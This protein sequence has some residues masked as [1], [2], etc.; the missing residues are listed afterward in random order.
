MRAAASAASGGVAPDGLLLLLEQSL[1]FWGGF[2]TIEGRIIDVHHPQ[3]GQTVGGQ[4]VALP[5]TKG[6]AGTP[7]D[8]AEAIRLGVGP[9]AV[10]T[11]TI[12][13]NIVA[14]AMV[15][16][17]LYGVDVPILRLNVDDF[18]RL[19]TGQRL[20]IAENGTIYCKQT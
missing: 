4:I 6:S 18:S 19:S 2:D 9:L 13:L 1:S 8:L 3:S 15:A 17:K 11:T 12:D 14:G 10:I 20:T 16:S 5:E 7:A